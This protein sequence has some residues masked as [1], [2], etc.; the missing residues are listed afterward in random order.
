MSDQVRAIA[1]P[2][3]DDILA[4][5]RRIEGQARGLQRM[6]DEG[7][8]CREIFPQIA[9]MKAALNS[10]N[11]MVLECYAHGCLG[12]DATAGTREESVSELIDVVLKL[13]R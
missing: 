11:A 9:A 5:L 6:V 3:R 2:A 7:R 1:G 12:G 8:D 4:R 13:S 10:V